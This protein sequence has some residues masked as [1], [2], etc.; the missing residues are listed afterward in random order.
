M[1]RPAILTAAALAFGS[2][3]KADTIEFDQATYECILD[4][5]LEDADVDIF[6]DKMGLSMR[7]A[8]EV[9]IDDQYKVLT[10]AR[11][12]EGSKLSRA[13]SEEDADKR[14]AD[15][16]NY[17]VKILDNCLDARG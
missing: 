16:E 9:V 12:A 13:F 17:A 15:Y 7:A 3:A 8:F 2:G 1:K 4:V 11:I 6:L 14:D 5:K 10:V